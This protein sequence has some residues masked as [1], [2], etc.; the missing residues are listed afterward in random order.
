MQQTTL[1]FC[2]YCFVVR[3]T[4]SR[5]GKWQVGFTI[6][7]TSFFFEPFKNTFTFGPKQLHYTHLHVP[8][9]TETTSM[10]SSTGQFVATSPRT[11]VLF[12]PV[13]TSMKPQLTF[14]EILFPSSE[15]HTMTLVEVTLSYQIG[16][17]SILVGLEK[18][19]QCEDLLCFSYFL[20]GADHLDAVPYQSLCLTSSR[21]V[22][23]FQA[24]KP[25]ILKKLINPLDKSAFRSNQKLQLGWLEGF[26]PLKSSEILSKEKAAS[27]PAA[28]GAP[29]Q[30]VGGAPVPAANGAPVLAASDASNQFIRGVA[31]RYLPSKSSEIL[32]KEK[33]AP[34]SA[35]SD[36]PAQ[37]VRGA[38][39]WTISGASSRPALKQEAKSQPEDCEQPAL[40]RTRASGI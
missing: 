37:A 11:Y 6:P 19:E 39:P 14:E 24:I 12:T 13:V 31:C 27:A 32:A 21:V 18:V 1:M 15:T 36:N 25:V 16:P 9:S 10:L 40:K 17:G 7:S 29:A 23:H 2:D 38:A 34:A 35:A 5:V 30:A 3:N 22:L 20:N 26:M 8:M 4:A 28:S 33:A